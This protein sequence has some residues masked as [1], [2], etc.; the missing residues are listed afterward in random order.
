M[1]PEKKKKIPDSQ[2]EELKGQLQHVFQAHSADQEEKAKEPAAKLEDKNREILSLRQRVEDTDRLC[3]GAR[4]E[5]DKLQQEV[6]HMNGMLA[7][8]AAVGALCRKDLEL[9][10]GLRAASDQIRV[11]QSCGHLS[12]SWWV[13]DHKSNS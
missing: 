7:Q 1:N 8:D 6:K 12:K 9:G 4:S 10:T 3:R 2:V 5:R 11:L 13:S